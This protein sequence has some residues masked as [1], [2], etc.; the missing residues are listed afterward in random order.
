MDRAIASALEGLRAGEGGPFGALVSRG[1]EVI[2]VA[3]NRVLARNDPTAHA[4]VEAIRAACAKLGSFELAGCDLYA[5]CEPCPMCFA[6]AYWARV[7][8]VI[9]ACD[10]DDAGRAGFD[11]AKL[12]GEMERP[13]RERSLPL[14]AFERDAGLA[15]FREW[16]AK[17]DKRLY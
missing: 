1:D 14:L 15:V 10:R 6:A 17:P 11:D 3:H 2:A 5:T 4:E 9:H 8:R 12:H 13:P 16:L 7:D